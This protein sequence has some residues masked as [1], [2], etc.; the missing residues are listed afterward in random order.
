MNKEINHKS[1]FSEIP[2]SI[3]FGFCV[4]NQ[5]TTREIVIKNSNSYPVDFKIDKCIFN[6]S[7]N[8]GLIQPKSKQTV[9]ISYL[10]NDAQVYV[11]SAIFNSEYEDSK[12][13]KIS[14]IG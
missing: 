8:S 13:L 14:A 1:I 6:I 9:I 10:P 12:I 7:P 3:D 4:V 2:E 5:I 11:A